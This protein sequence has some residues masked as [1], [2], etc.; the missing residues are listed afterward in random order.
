MSLLVYT[1]TILTYFYPRSLARGMEIF[2]DTIFTQETL[3]QR[4]LH[5]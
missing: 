4:H 2:R 5:V 3:Q 1:W